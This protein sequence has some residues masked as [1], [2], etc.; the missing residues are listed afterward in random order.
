MRKRDA[1][2]ARPSFFH[3]SVFI[4]ALLVLLAALALSVLGAVTFGNADLSVKDVYSVILYEVFR[5]DSLSAYK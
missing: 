3:T 5:F 2:E 4:L 1:S